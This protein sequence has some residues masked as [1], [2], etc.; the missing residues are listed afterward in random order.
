MGNTRNRKW[1]IELPLLFCFILL[2]PE[3]ASSASGYR[4]S[5]KAIEQARDTA[6]KES[7]RSLSQRR[8]EGL[9]NLDSSHVIRQIIADSM[10][11]LG[12]REDQVQTKAKRKLEYLGGLAFSDM[13][14]GLESE[15]RYVRFW[16]ASLLVERGSAAVAALSRAVRFDPDGYVRSE[17]ASSLGQIYDPKA[18]PAL[19]A[20]LEDEDFR[21]L[22]RT[23]T[24]LKYLKAKR[25]VEPLEK[26]LENTEVDGQLRRAAAEA[27][28]HIDRDAGRKAIRDVLVKETNESLSALLVPSPGSMGNGY[29]PPDLLKVRQLTKDATTLAGER[30]GSAEFDQ[31]LKHIDSPYW[32]VSSGCLHALGQLNV[33]SAVPSII[34]LGP[35][36]ESAY[37]ALAKIA[38]PQALTYL[39][40]AI[41]SPD[42]NIRATAIDALGYQGGRWAVP[43]LIELLDDPRLRH[44]GG[45]NRIAGFDVILPDGHKAHSV[46]CLCLGRAGLQGTSLNLVSGKTF[47]VDAEI[48]RL[49]V[50]WE[51]HGD[52]FLR[53]KP[54]P[55][56]NITLVFLAG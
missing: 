42:E 55:N 25:A 28:F 23:I 13:V 45:R 9:E 40:E 33:R 21:V 52:D 27:L 35:K 24:A 50:W 56:P 53:G 54:V 38:S 17:A 39:L 16:C 32:A 49:K 47:D 15:N 18:I 2:M 30:F 14:K 51:K 44:K 19:L 37:N 26:I 8:P 34:A 6:K 20:A 22:S 7:Q 43:I 46:L 10:K 5:R 36:K 11:E 29:W 41:Q 48:K 1:R 12:D 3:A 31:L 4:L